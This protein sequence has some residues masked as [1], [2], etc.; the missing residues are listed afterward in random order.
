[1]LRYMRTR[2]ELRSHCGYLQYLLAPVLVQESMTEVEIPLAAPS[3][4]SAADDDATRRI[5]AL[6]LGGIILASLIL[7]LLNL[8]MCGRHTS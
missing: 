7:S 4:C 8:R 3:G 5:Y 1:M 2:A 6:I